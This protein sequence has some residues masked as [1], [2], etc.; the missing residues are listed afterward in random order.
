M[1]MLGI[2]PVAEVN[3]GSPGLFGHMRGRNVL[4]LKEGFF[5]LVSAL[6]TNNEDGVLILGDDM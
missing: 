2:R 5:I 3:L 4:C 6:D 1:E